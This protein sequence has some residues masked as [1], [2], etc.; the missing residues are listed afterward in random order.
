MWNSDKMLLNI[1]ILKN[2]NILSTN[3]AHEYFLKLDTEKG[4]FDKLEECTVEQANDSLC[5]MSKV[6]Q[7]A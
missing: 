1:A 7:T 6:T 3:S 2:C 4:K 5:L